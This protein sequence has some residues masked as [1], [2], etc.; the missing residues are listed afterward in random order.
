MKENLRQYHENNRYTIVFSSEELKEKRLH[1]EAVIKTVKAIAEIQHTKV[2]M[3]LLQVFAEHY[4]DGRA[5]QWKLLG[6]FCDTEVTHNALGVDRLNRFVVR[7]NLF[8]DDEIEMMRDVMMYHGRQQLAPAAMSE[9]TKEY[10]D[11]ITAADDFENAC[12]CVSYLINEV[13]TNNKGYVMENSDQDQKEVTH[14]FIWTCYENG[15]KFDK[16][17]YCHTYADY[18]LFAGTLATTCIRKYGD[19]AKVALLQSGYGYDTILGGFRET[20]RFALRE[21]DSERAYEIMEKMIR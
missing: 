5:D 7:N 20:F 19:I 2:D 10:V 1:I 21:E 6:K 9:R 8:L 16:M 18:I 3:E 14:G 4:D 11:L 15:E 17:K 13:K 12:S